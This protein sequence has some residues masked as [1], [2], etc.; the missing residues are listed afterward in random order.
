MT[1]A[2]IDSQVKIIQPSGRLNAANA[3]AFQNQ[4]A[5]DVSSKP[6]SC[7][8][9]DMHQVD[10]LDSAGLM[11][12]VS[13]LNLAQTLQRR[14]CLCNVSP[15]IRMIFELTQLDEAFEIFESPEAFVTAINN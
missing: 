5:A 10:F 14:F 7:L 11:A 9:V 1:S 3:V 6:H 8:L 4:L 2:T 13:A 12:L 15:S